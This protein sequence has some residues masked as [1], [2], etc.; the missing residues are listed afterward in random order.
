MMNEL[1]LAHLFAREHRNFDSVKPWVDV[2]SGGERQKI[3][4]ARIFYHKPKFAIL[5]KPHT[6]VTPN[7][8]TFA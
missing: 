3:S 4:F 1:D 5:G 8:L 6:P 2:L 7:F